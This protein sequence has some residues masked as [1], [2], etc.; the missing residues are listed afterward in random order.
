MLKI[1]FSLITKY[2]QSETTE[3]ENQELN[4]WRSESQ[5]HEEEFQRLK[6]IWLLSHSFNPSIVVKNKNEVWDK[7]TKKLQP[8][9]QA[10]KT[11]SR[12][13]I[14]KA[15]SI[16][17][18]I[19]LLFGLSFSYLLQTS[20]AVS[21]TT[22]SATRGQKAQIELPDGTLVWLNSDSKITYP[23]NFNANNRTVK[24]VGEAFFDVKKRKGQQFK[25]I[26]D[27]ISIHVFGTAFNVNAYPDHKSI[28]VAL[29][30][31]K[32]TV[33]ELSNDNVMAT[34]LPNQ[35]AEV[36][37][38]QKLICQ[39]SYC[40]AE[41]TSL[42][43]YGKLKIENVTMEEIAYK[44]E[45]W[46]GVNIHFQNNKKNDNKHYWMTIKTESLTEMLQV[47]NKVTPINYTIEGEEVN[48][49]YK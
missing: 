4:I 49:M 7:I 10:I 16:A 13:Y 19:A 39:L 1:P 12:S 22:V 8:T 3:L 46:Y 9:S 38:N 35:K 21:Y 14:I 2:L 32:V 31:G 30:R 48:I 47:I 45:H 34:L 15:I 37:K 44:M 6:D 20:Y 43:R 5:N 41:N 27:K 18:T 17:A 24:L 28:Q 25:V 26:A 29:L 40:N 23:S 36:F 42:W 11:Y 33:N